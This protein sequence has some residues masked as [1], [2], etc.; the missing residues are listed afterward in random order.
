MIGWRSVLYYLQFVVVS[1]LAAYRLRRE[2]L[3]DTMGPFYFRS[4]LI[5]SLAADTRITLER[6]HTETLQA[7]LRGG[8]AQRGAYST[9]I[10]QQFKHADVHEIHSSAVLS[11]RLKYGEAQ[12]RQ[13][14]S[15]VKEKLFRSFTVGTSSNSSARLQHEN[16]NQSTLQQTLL[17][18]YSHILYFC[19]MHKVGNRGVFM[20]QM[21]TL[22]LQRPY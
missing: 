3:L 12:T 16:A 10:A 18:T 6:P 7:T 4:A 8:Y 1:L 2:A 17:T 15:S 5:H 22:L 20:L 14:T 11:M 13:T 21:S 19:Q 9:A